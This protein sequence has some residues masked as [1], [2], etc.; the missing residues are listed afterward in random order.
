MSQ[1]LRGIDRDIAAGIDCRPKCVERDIAADFR[2]LG[3]GL[4]REYGRRYDGK[5]AYER[6]REMC[7]H[8]SLQPT[9]LTM[10]FAYK[11]MKPFRKY[12]SVHRVLQVG[13]KIN[14]RRSR[15]ARYTA[16]TAV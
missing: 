4:A 2:P 11:P 10:R 9:V 1:H 5:D 14:A 7:T 3:T 8:L 13:P 12:D 6:Q 15:V 16:S